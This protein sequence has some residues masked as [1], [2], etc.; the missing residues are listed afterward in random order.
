[1]ILNRNHT[2][3][4]TQT[5][6][7]RRVASLLLTVMLLIPCVS[8]LQLVGVCYTARL[9]AEKEVCPGD[10][11]SVRLLLD[12]GAYGYQGVLEYDDS[13]LKLTGVKPVNGKYQ[14]EFHFFADTGTVILTHERTVTKMVNL[15]FLV[16]DTA[17]LGSSTTVRFTSG[18]ILNGSH[19]E[20][21]NDA[22]FTVKFV[23]KKSSD[24]TL[25]SL[26]ITVFE[27]QEDERGF[28]PTL[29][30]A[31]SSKVD[32]YSATVPNE[33]TRYRIQAVP[34]DSSATVIVEAEGDLA[35]GTN[36][37][38]VKVSAEDG[39]EMEY[40]IVLFRERPP[41]ISQIVSGDESLTSDD[42]S[43]E[44]PSLPEDSSEEELSVPDDSSEEEP[45][46]SDDSSIDNTSDEQSIE[47]SD[48]V[49]EYEESNVSS[50]SSEE[51]VSV[52]SSDVID[53]SSSQSI[54]DVVITPFQ[55]EERNWTGIILCI[56]VVGGICLVA[57]LVRLLFLYRKKQ[58]I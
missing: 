40:T 2:K 13:V 50:D 26:N 22:S 33:Y 18:K 1:M 25:K 14:K 42:S 30:P 7:K 57:L 51:G 17:K 39:T 9:S 20:A 28:I 12:S 3:N 36:P 11:F 6:L 47:E 21:V 32:F 43:E 34:N 49:S 29:N 48:E 15:T 44:E 37:I 4:K 46:F 10:T 35:E 45:D 58:S 31:F 41:E 38:T 23:D 8:A 53:S 55:P 56:A 24:A 19:T 27:A 52:T 16:Y 54:N 5:P